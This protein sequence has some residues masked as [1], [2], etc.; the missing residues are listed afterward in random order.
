MRGDSAHAFSLWRGGAKDGERD[1]DGLRL[2]NAPCGANDANDPRPVTGFYRL[3][4]ER[5]FT[6]LAHF[7]DS[8]RMRLFILVP[9][10]LPGVGPGLLL[11]PILSQIVARNPARSVTL[12]H[13]ARRIGLNRCTTA[14]QRSD[15][16]SVH[17]VRAGSD[18]V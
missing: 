2:A 3:G 1:A 4:S 18:K 6:L 11:P 10:H 16:E 8:V 5:S 14:L 12:N 9:V 13:S 15:G 17:V 7:A